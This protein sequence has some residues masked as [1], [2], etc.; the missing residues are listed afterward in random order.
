M[1]T[2]TTPCLTPADHG[3][4]LSLDEFLDAEEQAGYRYEL[5]QGVLEVTQVPDEPHG[6]LVWFLVQA[7]V[8]YADAHPGSIQRVGE[9]SS[10][11]LW[12]PGMISGRN[13]DV[14]VV[15]HG[16]QRSFRG[17]RPPAVAFE[18]V[19]EGAEARHRDY[20]TKRAE[21]LAY[22]LAEYWIVDP[23]D[24][25]IIVLLR[26]GDAWVERLFHSDQSAQGLVLPGF[27]VPL[28]DLWQAAN[29]D[30]PAADAPIA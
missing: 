16:T 27:R 15:L 20:V 5:A 28:P 21:Y 17:Q 7:L 29:D 13:P 4:H 18:I 25:K 8:R 10:F 1:A 26:D 6:N 14:S 23:A 22:G 19:S 24:R 3:R 30:E 11:R 2:V 9:A 12:M